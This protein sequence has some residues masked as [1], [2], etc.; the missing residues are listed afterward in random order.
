MKEDLKEELHQKKAII[1]TTAMCEAFVIPFQF[2]QLVNNLISNS[3][4][5]SAENKSPHIIIKSEIA[6]GASFDN[7]NLE[8]VKQY[9][10]VSISD[11]G[12]GFEQEYSEKIFQVFQRLHGRHEYDG[13]GIGLAIVKKIVDNHHGFITAKSDLNN[14]A[15]FDI[16]IPAI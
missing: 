14:G 9:C 1:E 10:H 8:K 7:K 4:K 11:N 6:D 5:F 16:Y 2:R 12:I 3:L 13:T 15:T